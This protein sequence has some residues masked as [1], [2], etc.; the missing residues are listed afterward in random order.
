M[1]TRNLTVVYLDG[2]YRI[3]Q[4]GQWDGYPSGQGVTILNFLR[5][6]KGKYARFK[7]QV[8]KVRIIDEDKQKEITDFMT[9]IGASDGWMDGNQSGQFH[10][11]YPL[12]NR[13]VGGEILQQ[14]LDSE[15]DPIWLHNSL[16]FAAD[17][18]FCEWAYVIDFDKGSFEVYEGFNKRRLAKTQRFAYLNDAPQP[19]HRK[20]REYYPI[21][22]VKSF[23]L[24][25][26]PN[27][28]RFLM[29]TEGKK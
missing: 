20:L 24:T 9:T 15:E 12:L 22:L 27:K 5:S 21:R 2:D 26:L 8:R 4:Y 29:L 6:L 23:S 10:K 1:G 3:A 25:K 16:N 7:S 19:A 13:D 28:N 14:V 18:L 11:K 17:S